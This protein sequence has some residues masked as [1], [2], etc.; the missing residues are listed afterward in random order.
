VTHKT[1]HERPATHAVV[2]HSVAGPFLAALGFALAGDPAIVGR[3][4]GSS[5]FY[6]SKRGLSLWV[7]FDPVDS[8]CAWIN[9]GREWTPKGWAMLL[10]NNY[11]IL[12]QRFGLDVPLS[13]L[14]DRGEPLDIL[15]ERILSDLKRS[16]PIVVSKVSMD[17]LVAIENEEPAG[18]AV[19][20]IRSFG[21]N[22]AASVDISD[23]SEK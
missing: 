10:S 18:A 21:A 16:L 20:V 12:A 17:D 19:N 9:C 11:S 5:A 14:M 2:F 1:N 23:F 22:Y 13:Y 6:R 4:G 8:D 7:I 15:A 3:F